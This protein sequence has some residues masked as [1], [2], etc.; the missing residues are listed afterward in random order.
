MHRKVRKLSL[1]LV[2]YKG[3]CRDNFY[4]WIDETMSVMIH[5][6]VSKYYKIDSSMQFTFTI[7]LIICLPLFFYFCA[8]G[9]LNFI[10]MTDANQISHSMTYFW[11]LFTI[12]Q[13]YII[14]GALYLFIFCI[15][16]YLAMCFILLYNSIEMF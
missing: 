16:L 7:Y 15:G 12:T 13:R 6:I 11:A 2:H 4:Q 10:L 1:D 3:N 14:I 8:K 9:I 5:N